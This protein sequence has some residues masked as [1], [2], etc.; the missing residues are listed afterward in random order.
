MSFG[1]DVLVIDDNEN[2]VKSIKRILTQQQPDGLSAHYR[3]TNVPSLQAARPYL[4][5]ADIV[6]LDLYLS[7]SR[8]VE[9]FHRVLETSPKTPVVILTNVDNKDDALR[10]WK[11]GSYA[12][13]LKE[14]IWATPAQLHFRIQTTLEIARL[15]QKV[16]HFQGERV[17]NARR[18]LAV[19]PT[20]GKWRDEETGEWLSPERYMEKYARVYFSHIVCP[21]D[22]E[23]YKKIIDQIE[24][25]DQEDTE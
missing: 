1:I 7:D 19:C 13:L 23:M 21:A 22:S 6:L 17:G 15:R 12:Y 9:T 4:T 2:D 25:A 10:A 14:W 20:C 5:P 16:V 3:V 11:A 8:G 18:L 24:K